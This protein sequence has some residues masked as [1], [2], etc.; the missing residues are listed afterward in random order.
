MSGG[1]PAFA[2]GYAGQAGDLVDWEGIE[3]STSSL[4]MRRSAVELP[5]PLR[6]LYP[7]EPQA[8]WGLPLSERPSSNCA[9]HRAQSLLLSHRGFKPSAFLLFFQVSLRPTP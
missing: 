3:P 7:A 4:Q 8:K 6:V 2:R 9:I 5:A 1:G